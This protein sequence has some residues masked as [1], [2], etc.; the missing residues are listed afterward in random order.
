LS[1]LN[2]PRGA[3]AKAPASKDSTTAH[4][5]LKLVGRLARGHSLLYHPPPKTYVVFKA[6]K[7]VLHTRM[8]SLFHSTVS[9]KMGQGKVIQLQRRWS[10]LVAAAGNTGHRWC[11]NLGVHTPNGARGAGRASSRPSEG[12]GAAGCG[13]QPAGYRTC[14]APRP[15]LHPADS[16]QRR[17]KRERR[18]CV[19]G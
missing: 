13:L 14:G 10:G 15:T 8:L 3:T 2:W 1:I 4:R 19:R 18:C 6:T 16:P 11:T 9:T 5:I 12:G 7:R 17:R